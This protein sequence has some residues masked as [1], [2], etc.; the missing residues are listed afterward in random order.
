MAQYDAYIA[1]LDA[2]YTYWAMR[3]FQ[4]DKEIV[5]LFPTPNHP[6]YPS[7]HSCVLG[8]VAATLGDLFPE[9]AESINA[10]AAEMGSWLVFGERVC[11]A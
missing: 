9:Q 10:L 4:L 3:P 7:G 8:A 1:C 11:A 2:K 5:T 6:S